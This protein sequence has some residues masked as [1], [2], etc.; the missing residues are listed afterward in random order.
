[1][2]LFN[3][4]SF[5]P[6]NSQKAQ[7]KSQVFLFCIRKTYKKEK[8]SAYSAISAFKQMSLTLAVK[9]K[10]ILR[11]LRFLRFKAID[12]RQCHKVTLYISINTIAIAYSFS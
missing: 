4:N 7:N 1:M 6:Q 5:K 10:K 12:V 2:P 9:I 8:S 11:I 3:V